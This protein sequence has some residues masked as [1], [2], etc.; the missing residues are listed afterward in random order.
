MFCTEVEVIQGNGRVNVNS[1]DRKRCQRLNEWKMFV[2][3]I[4][5]RHTM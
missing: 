5:D 1:Y 3:I 2:I 4:D